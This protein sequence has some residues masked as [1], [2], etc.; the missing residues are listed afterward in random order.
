MGILIIGGLFFGVFL[1]RVFKVFVLVPT[2]LIM[3]A[4]LLSRVSADHTLAMSIAE[5][6]AFT[7][8]LQI[9]YGAGLIFGRLAPMSKWFRKDLAT[10][11]NSST[12]RSLHVR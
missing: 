10:H 5:I 9:G 4:I 12:S 11:A 8:S 7:I 6:I 3:F 1:G 2:N